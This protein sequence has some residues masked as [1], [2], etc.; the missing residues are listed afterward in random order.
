MTVKERLVQ[1][2]KKKKVSD[3]IDLRG[4]AFLSTS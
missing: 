4:S 2:L 3:K 1:Y